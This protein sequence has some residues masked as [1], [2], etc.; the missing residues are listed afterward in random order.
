MRAGKI[1]GGSRPKRRLR[2]CDSPTSGLIRTERRERINIHIGPA[3]RA[4]PRG[5]PGGTPELRGHPEALPEE[6]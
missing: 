6:G 1:F 4:R 2:I 3:A 5:S